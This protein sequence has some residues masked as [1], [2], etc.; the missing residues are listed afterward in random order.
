MLHVCTK[1]SFLYT[2]INFLE[3]LRRCNYSW[4][5]SIAAGATARRVKSGGGGADHFRRRPN[6][7]AT[8]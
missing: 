6:S 8:F 5:A 2:G 3:P 7:A 4:L 1:F